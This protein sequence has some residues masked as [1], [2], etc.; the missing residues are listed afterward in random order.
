[1]QRT[2]TKINFFKKED[3]PNVPDSSNHPG[4]I[5]TVEGSERNISQAVESI[6]H[7]I[8]KFENARFQAIIYEFYG[9][10]GLVPC[11]RK[12]I[13]SYDYLIQMI[14]TM[15]KFANS[16]MDSVRVKKLR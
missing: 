1:M 6:L 3:N 10:L 16:V 8:S 5:C 11:F 4:R 12:I 14:I 15:V 9:R 7:D 2:K 13:I